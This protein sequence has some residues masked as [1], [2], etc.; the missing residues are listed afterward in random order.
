MGQL[1]SYFFNLSKENQRVGWFA[2]YFWFVLGILIQPFFITYQKM[3]EWNFEGFGGKVLFALI[4][5]VIGFPAVYRIAF[6]DSQPS[7]VHYGT[8]FAAG[9]G[10]ESLI[11]TGFAYGQNIVK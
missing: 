3:G 4:L 1:Q 7:L 9:M 11:A 10:W 2:Q 6:E 8:I 5:G